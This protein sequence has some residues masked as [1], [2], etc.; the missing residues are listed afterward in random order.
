M[1]INGSA[2]R[3]KYLAKTTV[4]LAMRENRS[5]ESRAV[6][7]TAIILA[8]LIALFC[9]FGVI[10]PLMKASAAE[11]LTETESV[12]LQ[13]LEDANADYDEVLAKYESLN[14]STVSVT[15][16]MEP[17]EC[18]S[19]IDDNLV[20]ASNVEAYT[21]SQG[22]ITAKISGVTLNSISDIYKSLMAYDSVENVQIYTA[23]KGEEGSGTTATLTIKLVSADDGTDDT[24]ASEAK[25]GGE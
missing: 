3:K 14:I 15:G 16:S 18:L 10:D 22:I 24:Q 8:V 13:S 12:A 25:G 5:G 4:N 11:Q 7:P 9:K 23:A 17:M 19:L 6:V 21:V 1:D 20:A 2:G